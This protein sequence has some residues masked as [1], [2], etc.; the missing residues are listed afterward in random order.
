MIG[1]LFWRLVARIVTTHAVRRWL[2]QR[3]KRTPYTHITG[4]DG[5]TYMGRWW[6]FNPYPAKSDGRKRRWGD[7]LPSVRIHHIQRP[8][9]DRH[10]HDHP[11]D[12]RTIILA[13][14]YSEERPCSEPVYNAHG[15]A[16]FPG[17]S[18]SMGPGRDGRWRATYWRAEGYTGQLLFGEYHRIAEVS[19][20]GVWTLFI[21]WRYRGT[22]GFDVN[23]RKVP[24]REYLAAPG[25]R[26]DGAAQRFTID[27]PCVCGAH[28]G[29]ESH[30]RWCKHATGVAVPHG[31]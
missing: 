17:D 27:N 16:I 6:L 30:A 19:D 23:G 11:W 29:P 7:W 13:G 20:G 26:P 15:M 9:S 10:L 12:A 28:G 8:D 2:I 21:T 14:G 22:W 24:W 5:S 31:G 18:H 3:S 4:P 1:Q 25:A